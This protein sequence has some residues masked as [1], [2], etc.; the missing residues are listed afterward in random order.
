MP[1]PAAQHGKK[2][3][4]QAQSPARERFAPGG[5][6]PSEQ[7]RLIEDAT[8]LALNQPSIS[9]TDLDHWEVAEAREP[10]YLQASE[11]CEE[12]VHQSAAPAPTARAHDKARTECNLIVP[13]DSSKSRGTFAGSSPQSGVQGYP[14]AGAVHPQ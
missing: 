2:K 6:L 12:P 5:L 3:P 9:A 10:T 11:S 13:C 4:L 8:R 1:L 7:A 14:A